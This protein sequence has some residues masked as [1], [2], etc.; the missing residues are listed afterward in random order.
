MKQKL[1]VVLYFCSVVLPLFDI[2]KGIKRGIV[3][4][5]YESA[6]DKYEF[7]KESLWK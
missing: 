4:A 1:K 7:M 5:R 3:R 2:L 6:I